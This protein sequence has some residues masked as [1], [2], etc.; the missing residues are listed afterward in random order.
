[1]MTWICG[2]NT[3]PEM[4]FRRVLRVAPFRAGFMPGTRQISPFLVSVPW[5]LQMVASG[6][7]ALV[8][9]SAVHSEV[10]IA[11]FGVAFFAGR[12]GLDALQMQGCS[13]A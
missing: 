9:R 8:V 4:S 11:G 7:V 10:V 12:A 6:A 3:M 2:V 5:S 1:M 13:Q